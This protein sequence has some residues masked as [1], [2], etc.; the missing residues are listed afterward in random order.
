[1]GVP[2]EE[3]AV[4]YRTNQGPRLLIEK[5]ME[6]N[7]PFHMRDTVPNLYEHWISKN[8]FAYIKAARGD[9]SRANVLTFI[10]RPARYISRD[11]LEGTRV[12]W[13]QVKSFYQDKNWMLDRIEQLETIYARRW[14]MMI[15]SEITP[16]S[17]G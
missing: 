10:N 13:E 1:M 5:L 16:R 6:Y 2:Y 3:M 15:I 14:G 12:N 7:I 8:I 9:V 4:L 17:G 11:A